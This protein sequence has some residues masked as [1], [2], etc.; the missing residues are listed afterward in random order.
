MKKAAM[1]IAVLCMALMLTS[2][3]QPPLQEYYESAQ[4]YLGCGDYGYA[5]ELFDQLGE[6]ED[7]AEY[8]LYC[9]ALQAMEEGNAALARKNLEAIAPFKSSDRYLMLLDAQALEA[10]SQLEEALAIYDALGTFED[11]HEKA[12][13]LR[14]AIPEAAIKQGRA[15]MSQGDY[16]AARELFLALNGYGQSETLAKSCTVAMN[17][18][19]YAQADALFDAG[20]YQAARDAFLA[21]GDTL[22]AAKRAQA[23]SDALL[24]DL[25]ARYAQV[26]VATAQ[27][28][29]ADYAAIE[30]D[31]AA[32]ARVTE[33]TAR[34]GSN[35]ALYAMAAEQ[36]CILLGRYPAAESGAEHDV[37][38]RLLRLEGSEA[39]FLCETVLDASPV[40]TM[41]HL[42]LTDA[43]QQ[44]VVSAALPAASDLS[45]LTDL[46]CAA[47]PYA[48]AQ[49]TAHENGLAL[50]WLRDSLE[51]GLHPVISSTGAMTL[52]SDAVTP[53]VR[54]MI[55]LSLEEIIF[56]LGSG[57]PEDPFR[58]AE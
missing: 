36:P 5:A 6:Y 39:T 21:L 34:Y 56:T 31:P 41:T 13:E 42:S 46:T 20:D 35:L 55:T 53:G 38:W 37:L 11:S 43:Q 32:A 22:D 51:S 7:S 18:A 8:T 50:Y 2:C 12:A 9:Q 26:T 25:E 17:K 52:P 10:D 14:K 24:S 33:L 47:T 40:A 16:A 27:A 57:T 45:S 48:L 23:C 29:I 58:T 49:G 15:L 4:L 1:I 28:L 3:A 54:P 44:A 30:N 19:A